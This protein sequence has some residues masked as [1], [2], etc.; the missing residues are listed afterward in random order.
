MKLATLAS[1]A[2][3]LLSAFAG[4]VSASGLR[5]VAVSD[6]LDYDE[7]YYVP[8]DYDE[9]YDLDFEEEPLDLDFFD[10]EDVELYGRRPSR[11]FNPSLKNRAFRQLNDNGRINRRVV[12]QL[13]NR[14]I[15]R[16]VRADGLSTRD[17]RI[18][19]RG[20]L[21]IR[22]GAQQWRPPRNI[23]RFRRYYD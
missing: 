19:R 10:D 15:R 18:N 3:V 1:V 6:S 23:R 9:D 22:R 4:T 12:R 17:V 20:D 8:E 16:V 21:V 5:G 2:A 7:N 14:Q 11:R 13:N